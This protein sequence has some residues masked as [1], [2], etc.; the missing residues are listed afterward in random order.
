LEVF[1]DNIRKSELM[2][3]MASPVFGVS[4]I[5]SRGGVSRKIS[6]VDQ[7][8]EFENLFGMFAHLS[9]F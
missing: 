7:E 5:A 9:K 2:P 3:T 8:A 1:G 6:V 4:R